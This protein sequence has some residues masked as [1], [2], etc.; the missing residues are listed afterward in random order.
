MFDHESLMGY[1]NV[2]GK[3]NWFGDNLMH[4]ESLIHP[5]N[6]IDKSTCRKTKLRVAGR[7]LRAGLH[8]QQR[9]DVRE[10]RE[11]A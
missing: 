9:H 8:E 7:K 2:P 6:Q 1:V 4:Q 3:F 11:G 10:S 5:R